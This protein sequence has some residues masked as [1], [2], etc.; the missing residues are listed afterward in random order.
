MKNILFVL[1][2]TL[3]AMG[4][5]SGQD[6]VNL[7]SI[8]YSDG[9]VFKGNT[10]DEGDQT[11]KFML[12]STGDTV[13][14]IKSWIDKWI[15]SEDYFMY[16]GDRYHPKSGNFKSFDL[17]LGSNLM[18]SSIQGSF[19]F[20]KLLSPKLGV[21]VGL[22]INSNSADNITYE[23]LPFGEVFL[24]GKYYLN[25]NRRRLFIDSKIGIGIPLSFNVKSDYTT[26]P[27]LQPGIGFEF[28]TTKKVRWSFKLSQFMQRTKIKPDLSSFGLSDFETSYKTVLNRTMFGL[29]LN[30]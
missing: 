28:A 3:Y 2:I 9:A 10:I 12:S 13:E 26:G 8:T 20:G 4:H 15:K 18:N 22:G 29:S 6:K 24:Y 27:L 1:G 21:G 11:V 25:N 5:L 30:F 16:K 7:E 23:L 17:S 14:L 19:T